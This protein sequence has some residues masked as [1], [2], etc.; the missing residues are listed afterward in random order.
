MNVQKLLEQFLGPDAT[1]NLGGDRQA[2]RPGLASRPQ[3]NLAGQGGDSIGDLL[4]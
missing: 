4:R 2:G 3:G 1:A